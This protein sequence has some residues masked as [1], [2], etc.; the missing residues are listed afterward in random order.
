M[1]MHGPSYK[2]VY[3]P[4]YDLEQRAMR[5]NGYENT[6]GIRMQ[7]ALFIIEQVEISVCF[8][9]KF[10]RLLCNSVTTIFSPCFQHVHDCTS[11]LFCSLAVLTFFNI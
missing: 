2:K 1:K 8:E 10:I 3:K 9:M 6:S 4:I 5:H 7:N 11:F